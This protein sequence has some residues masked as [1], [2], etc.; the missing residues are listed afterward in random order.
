M[1]TRYNH[2]MQKR[3]IQRT[4]TFSRMNVTLRSMFYLGFAT[5]AVNAFCTSTHPC[6]VGTATVP[7][8]VCNV[9]SADVS[10]DFDLNPSRVRERKRSEK[11]AALYGYDTLQRR[12]TAAEEGGQSKTKVRDKR[13]ILPH[14]RRDNHTV[15]RMRA[16]TKI[17]GEE[18]K[19][20]KSSTMPGFDDHSTGQRVAFERAIARQEQVTGKKV[21]YSKEASDARKRSAQEKMYQ[22]SASVPDSLLSFTR[23]IHEEERITPAEEVT[24]GS[25]TQE[26]IRLQN[27]KTQLEEKLDR[28]PTDEEWCAAA[29]KINM[30]CLRQCLD[31]GTEAK[32]KLVVSNLRMVQRVVNLY[33]RNGLGS[34]YNAGDMMQEGTLALIRAAEKFEPTKGF[35]FSTYAM[36][37]IRASV[38]RSQMLQ[39]RLINVPQRVHETFKRVS[40]VEGELRAELGR[41]PTKGEIA[42]AANVT[43]EQLEKCTE[44]MRQQLMSLDEDLQNNKKPGSNTGNR[45]MDMYELLPDEESMELS[46]QKFMKE[47]LIKSL[48]RH[49]TPLEVAILCL[50]YGLIDERTLPHGFSGPLTIR[51]V[52]LLVGL[53]PDKVRRTINKS[54]RRL[55]YL[56]AHEWPQ[57]SQEVLEELKE[58]QQF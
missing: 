55:K 6:S 5:T 22:S 24:L 16:E 19:K 45:K 42:R 36:Y 28:E 35:R 4:G 56:I 30:T 2:K 41:Q 8:S 1:L 12:S 48:Q 44:A 57:Y 58:Q 31:E 52:S 29:G 49:L 51:E 47:D 50:R 33:I 23:E 10:V 20:S 39:S 9:A 38:K 3:K 43:V 53:K 27:L 26:L 18:K 40:K 21:V 32:E 15:R 13:E 54:L 11:A 37:W 46:N 17:R 25:K 34:E 14:A 7:L